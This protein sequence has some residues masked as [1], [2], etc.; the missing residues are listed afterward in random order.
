[1]YDSLKITDG[2]ATVNE[3]HWFHEEL[4]QFN[5][6][7]TQLA[8]FPPLIYCWYVWTLHAQTCMTE[9]LPG[10]TKNNLHW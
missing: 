9:Q 3:V 6:L 1:M 4:I 10:K 2:S 8:A 7:I 5:W